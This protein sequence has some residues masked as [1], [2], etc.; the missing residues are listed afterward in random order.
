VTALDRPRL[1]EQFWKMGL[2]H[3]LT[4]FQDAMRMQQLP[5]FNT[6]YADRDGHIMYLYNAAVPVRAR[7]DYQFWS[8]VVLGDQSELI[9]SASML[10]P[11]RTRSVCRKA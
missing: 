10:A 5:L 9:W 6:A 8:G 3:N 11:G 1:F 2:A 7:G 4:Q